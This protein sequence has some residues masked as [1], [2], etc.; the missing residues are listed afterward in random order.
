MWPQYNCISSVLEHYWY[1]VTF[2]RKI[3]KCISSVLEHYWYTVT[4]IRKRLF[5]KWHCAL[6]TFIMQHAYKVSHKI[7]FIALYLFRKWDFVITHIRSDSMC[8]FCIILW[9]IED[10]DWRIWSEQ[11]YTFMSRIKRWWFQ[12]QHWRC[13]LL[14]KPCT[15]I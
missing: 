8:C 12:H 4:F 1:T 11:T 13:F 5:H 10:Y 15:Y 14:R 2:I 6:K 9:I 7:S 3:V